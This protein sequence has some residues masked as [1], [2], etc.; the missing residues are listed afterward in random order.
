MWLLLFVNEVALLGFMN[1]VHYFILAASIVSKIHNSWLQFDNNDDET[2]DT[3]WNS[4]YDLQK[5]VQK[6]NLF[7]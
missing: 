7:H 2:R 1:K 3:K 4:K 5:A 6:N